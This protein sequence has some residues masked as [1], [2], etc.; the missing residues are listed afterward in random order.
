MAGSG[1]HPPTQW[2][3]AAFVPAL[4]GISG[5]PGKRPFLI[6]SHLG[7]RHSRVPGEIG[8]FA[9]MRGFALDDFVTGDESLRQQF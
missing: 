6:C 2:A 1:R 9:D 8:T 3:E 5:K 4:I 7:Q